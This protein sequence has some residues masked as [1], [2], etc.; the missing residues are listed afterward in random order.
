MGKDNPRVIV[1]YDPDIGRCD[2]C[3][4][5]EGRRRRTLIDATIDGE[6]VRLVAW[7]CSECRGRR[8]AQGE[9]HG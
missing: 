6:P 9:Y 1:N 3:G 8:L 7:L 5:D 2:D 4:T